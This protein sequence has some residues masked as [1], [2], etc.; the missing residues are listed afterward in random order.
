[1]S[2]LLRIFL[3]DLVLADL[4]FVQITGQASTALLIP[5]F[6]LTLGSPLLS[7]LQ[8]KFIYRFVW[9]TSVLLVFLY[10]IRHIQQEGTGYLL[11]DGLLLAAFCQVHILNNL[12]KS[13]KP[14]LLFFN[15]FLIPL[16]TSFFTQDFYFILVFALFVPLFLLSLQLYSLESSGLVLGTSNVARCVRGSLKRSAVVL[17]MTYLIFVFLPRDFERKGWAGERLEEMIGNSS[18][19]DFGGEIDLQDSGLAKLS[20][21]IVV[22]ARLLSGDKGEVPA[23]WGGNTFE[24]YRDGRWVSEKRHANSLLV[25]KTRMKNQGLLWERRSDTR[26]WQRGDDPMGPSLLFHIKRPE[27]YRIKLL[28]PT[29]DLRIQLLPPTPPKKLAALADGTL[30][31]FRDGQSLRQRRIFSYK[32]RTAEAPGLGGIQGLGSSRNDVYRGGKDLGVP[33]NLLNLAD[34]LGKDVSKR[35]D[36]HVRVDYFTNYLSKNY[37]YLGPAEPGRAKSLE[38]FISKDGDGHCE[39]FATALTLVLRRNKIPCRVVSGYLSREWDD[40]GTELTFRKRDAHSW[41]EVLDPLGGWY[42]VDTSPVGIASRT[43]SEEE[44]NIWELLGL[45]ASRFWDS[46]SS[47]DAERRGETLQTLEALL[48]LLPAALVGKDSRPYLIG[49]LVVLPSSWF[50]YRR[51]RRSTFPAHV[52]NYL[53]ALRKSRIAPPAPGQTPRDLLESLESKDL[54]QKTLSI[55]RNATRRHELHRYGRRE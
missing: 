27:Q 9:N 45:Q 48:K 4:V 34:Q 5:L 36:Q 1:M 6:L 22:T 44:E 24:A 46:L 29:G 47:F 37:R 42:V 40:P 21:K 11:Q 3:L 17:G 19:V 15:A 33:A 8:E 2:L 41:V 13:Q 32:V 35:Y 12:G 55:I 53:I 20:S 31:V 14:D 49:L 18:E 43:T 25:D 7:R 38:E 54:P 52:Q 30:R 50:F 26:V 10:L 16:V 23:Y 51:R 39:F 28:L